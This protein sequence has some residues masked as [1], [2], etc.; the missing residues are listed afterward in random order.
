M[1]F[2]HRQSCHI[3]IQTV[4]F[5]FVCLDFYVVAVCLPF[6]FYFHLISL[7]RISRMMLDSSREGTS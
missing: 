3:R 6:G 7:A 5:P 2:L 1:G 4:L